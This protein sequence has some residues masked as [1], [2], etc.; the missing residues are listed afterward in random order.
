MAETHGISF[1]A[2]TLTIVVPTKND[3][4]ELHDTLASIEKYCLM[5]VD[6]VVVNSGAEEP[7]KEMIGRL[8]NTLHQYRYF[9]EP[10]RGVFPAQNKGIQLSSSKW[11]MILNA[12][13]T[14]EKAATE[15]LQPAF[16]SSCTDTDILVF[17]QSTYNAAGPVYTFQP[18][19][20]SFWPHQS[21]LMQKSVHDKFG[22]YREDLRYAADQYFF[23]CVRKQVRC[24]IFSKV[25][26]AYKLGGISS[27]V[28][29]QSSREL[30]EV[31]K[32]LGVSTAKAFVQ[33]YVLPALRSLLT[34][35][36]GA[37]RVERMKEKF[38]RHYQSV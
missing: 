12:G 26:T 28:S 27:G 13:D 5:P 24:V 10:P 31:R 23:A 18:N 11:M 38:F 21:I 20:S 8:T 4:P 37:A 25:L 36:F 33:S 15:I 19:E 35:A 17:A 29:L 34:S 6:V 7:V 30:F 32:E 2:Q 22:L 3:L 16:L 9:Y 14:L 1:S